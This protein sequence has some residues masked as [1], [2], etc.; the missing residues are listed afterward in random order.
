MSGGYYI[1]TDDLVR[2]LDAAQRAPI[3]KNKVRKDL[4]SNLSECIRYYPFSPSDQQHTRVPRAYYISLQSFCLLDG[5]G[6][7]TLSNDQLLSFIT[8]LDE[9]RY[10]AAADLRERTAVDDVKEEV[11]S[12]TST[13]IPDI[14]RTVKKGRVTRSGSV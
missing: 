5:K 7:D 8:T 10:L 14:P 3:T 11:S 6:A 1:A 4:W 2:W 9:L 13:P 12:V